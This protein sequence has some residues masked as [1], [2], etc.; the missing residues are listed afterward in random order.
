M[1]LTID[2]RCPEK[3]TGVAIFDYLSTPNLPD[4]YNDTAMLGDEILD[5]SSMRLVTFTEAEMSDTD[6]EDSA[7][8]S[9]GHEPPPKT[10]ILESP[11]EEVIS[12]SP[13]S[14]EKCPNQVATP[15]KCIK[16]FYHS[17]SLA[18]KSAACNLWQSMEYSVMDSESSAI[19]QYGPSIRCNAI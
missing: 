17:L 5:T 7:S 10:L 1:Q 18:T 14:V 12:A 9:N 13:A 19:L 4:D 6:G 2:A 16:T 15:T 11:R 3:D 8:E